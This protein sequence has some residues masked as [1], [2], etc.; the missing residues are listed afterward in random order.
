VR[1]I[2][3]TQGKAAL[4]DDADYEALAA[5]KWYA[6]A[7]HG[8][9]YASRRIRIPGAGQVV[10]R[11]HR[12][13]IK[14]PSGLYVDH[15]DGNGLDNR[16]L[17]LRLATDALNRRNRFRRSPTACGLPMGVYRSAQGGRYRAMIGHGGERVYLGS[18]DTPESAHAAYVSA[19]NE[20]I[21][22][23]LSAVSTRITRGCP[24]LS[25]AKG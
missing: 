9:F 10:V 12:Q 14:P 4:V 6:Q 5:F 1:T 2:P 23:E 25:K 22:R 20:S 19:R 21:R 13:I 7:S 11:V 15:I 18:F 16:R 8:T 17:N 24:I 3:L